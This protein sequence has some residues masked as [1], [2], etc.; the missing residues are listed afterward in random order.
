MYAM[1]VEYIVCVY[2]IQTVVIIQ[3]NDALFLHYYYDFEYRLA[4]LVCGLIKD[5]NLNKHK[6]NT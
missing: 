4:Q 5:V 1:D 6:R 3:I 2:H